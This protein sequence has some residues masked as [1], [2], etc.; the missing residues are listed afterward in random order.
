MVP[1]L[2][3]NTEVVLVKPNPGEAVVEFPTVVTLM[4]PALILKEAPEEAI[5]NLLA[6]F[7]VP[8]S[9]MK[10]DVVAPPIILVATR[11]IFIIPLVILNKPLMVGEPFQPVTVKFALFNQKPA[12]L[13]IE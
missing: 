2:M 13:A 12:V 4:V 9:F 6:M 5:T 7:I 10:M 11:P 8:P 1:P 3:V